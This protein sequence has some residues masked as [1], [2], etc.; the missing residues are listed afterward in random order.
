MHDH[1]RLGRELELF[2]ADPLSG[3]GLPVWLPA[4]AAARHSVEEYV[5][6]L[7]RRAG[8]QHVYSPPLGKREL[9]EL[10][11]HLGYF[12]GDMFPVLRLSDDDEFV[13][14]PALCPHHALVYRARGRS[15]RE[16]PLRIA[17]LG[18][19]YRPERSGVLGGLSR[20][21]AI[22]LNDA[23]NFC[24]PE[25]V[26]AEVA[27][28]L[29][30]IRVAHAALGVRPAGFR[31]SL[32]GPGEKYVGDDEEW[33]H[34]EDLLRAALSGLPYVE[35]PGEAAF[36]G[37]KIDIQVRDAAGREST[38]STIQ[39]DF[40]K[41]ARFD[42]CYADARGRRARPVMVHRSLVGSMER[43]FGYLIEVHAGA[44]PAW[45]APV[46]VR[47]LPV[48]P[49]QVAAAEAFRR[50]C[51]LAGL[52][53][54]LV[55][56]GSLGARIRDAA[57]RRVPYAAVL[58]AREVAAGQVALRLRDGRGV[59]PMAAPDALGLIAGVVAGRSA[60]LLP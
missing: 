1:R 34:A 56:D 31:L 4:G 32:R 12:A 21:R 8:Y 47:V 38:L 54:E 45:Y 16:L 44:F 49:E 17:E 50:D 10:S 15:Y 20:V 37:P 35:A 41:P 29:E 33:R 26:G 19:M 23:H 25:Q 11:G 53:A 30:L 2:H 22:S 24:P 39:L 46:Q 40:D 3:A 42:L 51:V 57:R 27:E 13:L 59:D 14:R 36:Y 52:R 5:R 43:L 58:G 28:V 6:E 9:F 18:G 60:E 48:G 55:V 7:E